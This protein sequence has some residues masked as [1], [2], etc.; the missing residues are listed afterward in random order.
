MVVG[1]GFSRFFLGGNSVTGYSQ[2]EA[3]FKKAIDRQYQLL[4]SGTEADI[5]QIY[6][7]FLD[8]KS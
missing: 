4:E 2:D 7:D 3:G 1:V 6:Q 8:P 5:Q